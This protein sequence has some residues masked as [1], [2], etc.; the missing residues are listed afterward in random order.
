MQRP[1]QHQLPKASSNLAVQHQSAADGAVAAA[2][3][4]DAVVSVRCV[5]DLL[6]SD[7]P[8]ALLTESA[9]SGW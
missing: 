3:A 9:A 7:L 6:S 2:A 4:A 5:S 1:L 8:V